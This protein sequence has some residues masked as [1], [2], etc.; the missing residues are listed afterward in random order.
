M[1]HVPP[2]RRGGGAHDGEAHPA[3]PPR[4]PRKD[5]VGITRR[6]PIGPIAAISPFNFPLDLAAH[7]VRRRS[8]SGNPIVLKPPSK[9]PLVMLKVAEI[10]DAAG[11]ARG[12]GQRPADEPRAGRPDGV[13]RPV[14][15]AHVHGLASVGWRMKD[16]RRQEEGRARARRQ[17]RASS[18]TSRPTSTGPS[19]AGRRRVRLLRPGLHQRPAHV[20]AR[21]R[22]GRVHGHV[23]RRRGGAQGRR[24]DGPDD[25][26]RPDGRRRPRG[27][28]QDWVDE[29]T[30]LGGNVLL[31]GTADGTFFAP[32]ILTD[33][34]VH[35]Q[36]LLERGVRAARG[37]VPVPRLR[38][39]D[40]PGQR[41]ASSAS[42][43]GVF[44]NDLAARVAGLQR[45]RGR[46][47]DR[48]R[49]PDLPGRPHAL[50]RRQGLRPRP[51]GPALGDRGHDRDRGSWSSPGPS[52]ARAATCACALGEPVADGRPTGWRATPDAYDT[53]R[54]PLEP[55]GFRRRVRR[56]GSDS[57]PSLELGRR[58]AVGTGALSATIAARTRPPPG[59]PAFDPSAGLSV[60]AARE[61]GSREPVVF[62]LAVGWRRAD[63]LPLEAHEADAGRLLLRPS[64]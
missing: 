55:G 24:P 20:R 18:S 29:A 21:G 26:R 17:R 46:R 19:S 51:R 48:Q 60:A 50:R 63:A 3:R 22:L 23:R 27:R 43:P 16:A 28:T 13:G 45:A 54:R 5:R 6:F 61:A 30:A 11:R 14:Q 9:D 38:R 59:R 41:L 49:R 36:G 37:G 39:G 62:V 32:T 64:S 8:P 57:P 7:K 44:T 1:P 33:V 25:R 58:G 10:I 15:A 53:L 35:A 2:R 4:R 47:R 52:R 42:R 34:A 12:H 56:G 40:P 31:G